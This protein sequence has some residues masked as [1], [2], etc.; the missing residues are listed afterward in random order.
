MS[1]GIDLLKE[2]LEE[3][4]NEE[5]SVEET[6]AEETPAEETPAEETPAE[7]TPAEETPA[8]ETPAEET[9]TISD[10]D[11]P[12]NETVFFEYNNV[13]IKHKNGETFQVS[14]TTNKRAYFVSGSSKK[15]C[16]L[17]SIVTSWKTL[18]N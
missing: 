4:I 12:L 13:F 6:P 7:E 16:P 3:E 2:L 9:E 18:K 8:E 10:K 11:F 1:N 17:S 14:K 15:F 5:L